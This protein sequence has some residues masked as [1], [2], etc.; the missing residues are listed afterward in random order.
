MLGANNMQLKLYRDADLVAAKLSKFL[1]QFQSAYLET[2]ASG[3]L[4]NGGALEK[5]AGDCTDIL[6]ALVEHAEGQ[7][8]TTAKGKHDGLELVAEVINKA[9]TVAELILRVC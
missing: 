5:I 7:A 1:D 3:G 2:A 8:T 6:L 9:L 4:P